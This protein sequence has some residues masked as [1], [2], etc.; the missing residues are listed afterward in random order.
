MAVAAPSDDSATP[1]TLVDALRAVLATADGAAALKRLY[2][3]DVAGLTAHVA[4]YV[5]LHP[6]GR[7]VLQTSKACPTAADLKR[8]VTMRAFGGCNHANALPRMLNS[9][10]LELMD[11]AGLVPTS[12]FCLGVSPPMLVDDVLCQVFLFH[13]AVAGLFGPPFD[14]APDGNR[15]RRAPGRGR[16]SDGDAAAGGAPLAGRSP[17]APTTLPAA[18][19][20]GQ[21]LRCRRAPPTTRRCPRTPAGTATR[22]GWRARPRAASRRRPRRPGRRSAASARR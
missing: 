22:P 7:L 2:G 12:P 9:A 3:G 5:L 4:A 16:A 13:D 19:R 8:P 1:T 10:R 18:R 15:R 14:L 17:L 11:E 6:S 21:R 20:R